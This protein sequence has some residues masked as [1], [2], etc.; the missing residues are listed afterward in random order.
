MRLDTKDMGSNWN[1]S[2]TRNLFMGHIH[3]IL[4]NNVTMMLRARGL[5]SGTFSD[6]VTI[7]RS[8]RVVQLRPVAMESKIYT[9]GAFTISQ[10]TTM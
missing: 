2:A 8:V 4:K 3:I 7:L 10:L 9:T 6:L 1:Q 5:D